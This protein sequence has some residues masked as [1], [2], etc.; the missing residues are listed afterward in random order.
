MSNIG[1]RLD[2]YLATEIQEFYPVILSNHTPS[3]LL[4]LPAQV[5]NL[6]LQNP[7]QLNFQTTPIEL[8]TA[9]HLLILIEKIVTFLHMRQRRP[10]EKYW[11]F[12]LYNY[13][14]LFETF[15]QD[16]QQQNLSDL[17]VWKTIDAFKI[18][19]IEIQLSQ[20]LY[21]CD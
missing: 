10:Q 21:S 5:R 19:S 15:L 16:Y 17:I 4:D 7:T 3:M 1:R 11:I 20:A 8:N 6:S 2:H 18:L 12:K 9:K 13:L 14:N